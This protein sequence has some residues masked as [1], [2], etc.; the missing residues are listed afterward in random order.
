MSIIFSDFGNLSEAMN[1]LTE[2]LGTAQKGVTKDD[3][4]CD[5][6]MSFCVH[7]HARHCS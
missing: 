6:S 4:D 1:R 3:N 7:C 2:A 5:V